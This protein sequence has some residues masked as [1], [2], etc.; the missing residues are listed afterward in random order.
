MREGIETREAFKKVFG[1]VCETYYWYE[2]ALVAL[3]LVGIGVY[4]FYLA[5]KILIS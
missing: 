2:V 3:A 5:W 1:Y 4:L